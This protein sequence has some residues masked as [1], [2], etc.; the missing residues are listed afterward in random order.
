MAV[1]AQGHAA[2]SASLAEAQRRMLADH[3]LQFRFAPLPD[4]KAPA[5]LKPLVEFLT[6]FGPVLLWVFWG[7]VALGLLTIA[8]LIAQQLLRTRWPE[9]FGGRLE[10]KLEP[11][12]WRPSGAQARALLEDVDALAAQGR[13]AE[14][15][16][17][18]L[19][20]SIADIQGRMP[21]LVRPALTSRDI[22]RSSGLPEVA[23]TAFSG[24][25]RVVERSHFG[26]APVGADDFA[27]CRSAYEAFAFPEVWA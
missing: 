19:F 24:I 27:E 8:Y 11:E 1:E 26:G 6:A 21:H 5:W 16:H 3:A 23:R 12:D 14:A 2:A 17:V 9:R 22:A 7:L 18:L 13:F 15:V 4:P 25:A 20:R 10:P